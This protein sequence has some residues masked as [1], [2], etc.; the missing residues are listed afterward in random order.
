MCV[1]YLFT[2]P[3]D[4]LKGL[5]KAKLSKEIKFK[6]HVFPR[7][8]APVI[9]IK[10]DERIIAAMQF[11]LIPFFEKEAKPKSVFHNARVESVHEKVSFKKAFFH[12]RCLIPLDS[13]FE[14]IWINDKEKY[15]ARFFPKSEETLTAA[16]IYSLWKSPDEKIIASFSMITKEPYP[17]IKKIGHDRSPLFLKEEHF[18]DWMNPETEDLKSLH[19]I[20]NDYAEIDFDMEKLIK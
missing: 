12:T 10:N 20:T 4:H 15:L 8:N 11:G 2:H 5:Y 9:V 19:K 16:G 17:F 1:Q 14:Y 18:D 7:Y 13:F 6:P 3:V